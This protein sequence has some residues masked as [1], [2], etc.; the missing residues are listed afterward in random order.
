MTAQFCRPIRS[1]CLI[2]HTAI[3]HSRCVG[4]MPNRTFRNVERNKASP[5]L[6]RQESLE[7]FFLFPAI[8]FICSETNGHILQTGSQKH[9][10]G[11]Y[12]K[13]TDLFE[14]LVSCLPRELYRHYKHALTHSVF[15]KR[16]QNDGAVLETCFSFFQTKAELNDVSFMITTIPECTGTRKNSIPKIKYIM[17]KCSI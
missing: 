16:Q 7:N 6:R 15:Y 4:G 11:V 14:N 2:Y 12:L 8:Q 5:F 17:Y 1:A 3:N 13:T 10:P 9:K